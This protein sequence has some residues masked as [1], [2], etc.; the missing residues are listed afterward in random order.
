MGKVLS[1]KME[2]TA[3]HKEFSTLERTGHLHNGSWLKFRRYKGA[4]WKTN[5][6]L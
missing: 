3:F 6:M 5:T 2:K 1:I 4:Q